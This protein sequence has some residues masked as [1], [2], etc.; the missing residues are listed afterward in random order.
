MSDKTICKCGK[1]RE[2]HYHYF[3]KVLDYCNPK[4]NQVFMAASPSAPETPRCNHVAT[5]SDAPNLQTGCAL[6]A[7]HSGLHSDG[8]YSWPAAPAT[9][10]LPPM[11]GEYLNSP[12][13]PVGLMQ[14]VSKTIAYFQNI[15][16]K[17]GDSCVYVRPGGVS[18][19]AV[20]LNRE[21]D[22][23]NLGVP[24][25]DLDRVTRDYEDLAK[26]HRCQSEAIVERFN[27]ICQLQKELS[28]A[29][30]EVARLN[31]LL[32]CCSDN[33]DDI[34][35]SL[36]ETGKDYA[37][38]EAELAASQ[39]KMDA[40]LRTLIGIRNQVVNGRVGHFGDHTGYTPQFS[41]AQVERWSATIAIAEERAK[42]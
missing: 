34:A 8:D 3:G 9:P 12:S 13:A 35:A 10:Q 4:G 18:W 6:N 17:F 1:I 39:K 2:H 24:G 5:Y 36:E 7:G 14:K 22:D 19:G 31:G 30:S 40:L 26:R 33:H 37:A 23:K 32:R 21:S 15:L 29:L 41:S 42:Q 38:L 11:D 25:S 27:R 20:A 16:D 28:A